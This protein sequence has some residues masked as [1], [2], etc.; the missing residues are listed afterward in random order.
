MNQLE[1]LELDA[2]LTDMLSEQ[3]KRVFAFF[4]PGYASSVKVDGSVPRNQNVNLRIAFFCPGVLYQT[5]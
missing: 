1:A 4:R 5:D 3:F 2:E